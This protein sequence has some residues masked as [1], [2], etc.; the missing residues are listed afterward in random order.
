MM[1]FG[2]RNRQ[3]QR[4]RT[5][6]AVP[7]MVANIGASVTRQGRVKHSKSSESTVDIYMSFAT[8]CKEVIGTSQSKVIYDQNGEFIFYLTIHTIDG[9]HI[10]KCFLESEFIG[11]AAYVSEN[12]VIAVKGK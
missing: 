5:R 9:N 6:V 8:V 1:R 2:T 12:L 3:R 10:I 11:P 7:A 4:E